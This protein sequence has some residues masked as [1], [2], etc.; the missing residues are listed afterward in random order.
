MTLPMARDLGRFKIRVATI[1]PGIFKTPMVAAMPEKV[2]EALAKDSDKESDTLPTRVIYS[3][4]WS[5]F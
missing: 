3:F 2:Q 4:L 1:A 5:C